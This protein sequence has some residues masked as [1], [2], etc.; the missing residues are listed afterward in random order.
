MG[1]NSPMNNRSFHK[2]NWT[3]DL[4]DIRHL[5][6]CIADLNTIIKPNLCIVDA[7]EFITTNGPFSPGNLVKTVKSSRRNR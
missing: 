1:L 4:A 3:N 2:P 7:T 5:D 6:Q